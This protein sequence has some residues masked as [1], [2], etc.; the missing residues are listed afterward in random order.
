[1]A[2]DSSSTSPSKGQA[3]FCTTDLPSDVVVEVE[4]MTF[5][6]H[7]SA[8]M[9]KSKTLH[10][11][12]TKQE[13]NGQKREDKDTYMDN[14]QD[15][16]DKPGEEEEEEDGQTCHVSLPHFPGGSETFE[17]VVKFCYGAK[18]E[19]TTGN[20]ASLWC[21]GEVLQMTED[22]A[23]DNLISKTEKFF[24]NSVFN[25]IKDSIKALKS[26]EKLCPFAEK[27][28]IVQRCIDAILAK[29]GHYDPT[30][31][32]W[33]VNESAGDPRNSP[34]KS[35]DPWVEDLAK[36][37]SDFFNRVISAMREK[38]IDQEIVDACLMHH[39]KRRFPGISRSSRGN[40]PTG[41]PLSIAS[42][43]EQRKL[44]ETIVSNL[45][46]ENSSRSS[47][48]TRFLFGLL[49]TAN[50]LNASDECK[51]ALERKISAQLENA[52]LD[53][54]LIPSY[55]Y[56]S[57]TLY[58]VDCVQRML[59]CSTM[60]KVI[61]KIDKVGSSNVSNGNGKGWRSKFGCKFT[62]K[63]CSSHESTV[64][65]DRKARPRRSPC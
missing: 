44:L 64:V 45:S 58:D 52:T 25:N 28:G 9:S 59:Q 23:Q 35:R 53:D 27:M 48:E 63:V 14:S 49:R 43:A 20:A 46:P 61:E 12:I 11:L 22:V 29:A 3:W 47:A 60:K 5:H 55:S 41:S 56:L 21:A 16:D 50:I 30:L 19:L 13:A 17:T 7:K 32:G 1:M 15:N 36:L 51:F 8:L 6:L 33:P 18:I 10:D 42:E 24:N 31:F 40:T 34:A 4:D 37:S 62:T 57:E 26:C 2:T 65:D 38:E 39:A 54:L